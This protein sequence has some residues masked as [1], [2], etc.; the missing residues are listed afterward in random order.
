MIGFDKA[1]V[2]LHNQ[3]ATRPFIKVRDEIGF[4]FYDSLFLKTLV[5]FCIYLKDSNQFLFFFFFFFS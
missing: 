1:V 3:S 2:H 5:K 4:K